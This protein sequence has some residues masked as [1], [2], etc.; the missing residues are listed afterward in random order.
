MTRIVNRSP[1]PNLN[2][3]RM[4]KKYFRF[5]K[6]KPNQK[7]NRKKKERVEKKNQ[8][9]LKRKGSVRRKKGKF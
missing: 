5:G 9:Y 6:K 1:D 8:K 3:E 4:K 2:G 7:K